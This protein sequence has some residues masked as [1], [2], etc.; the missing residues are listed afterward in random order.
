MSDFLSY[1]EDIWITL[2]LFV[3]CLV[4]CVSIGEFNFCGAHGQG[5]ELVGG[6][7]KGLNIFSIRKTDGR[8]VKASED[9][10]KDHFLLFKIFNLLLINSQ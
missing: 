5:L 1:Q 7:R 8:M 4:E 6:V 2:N 9:S 10:T 3:H